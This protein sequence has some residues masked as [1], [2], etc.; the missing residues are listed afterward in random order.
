M[1]TAARLFLCITVK[2]FDNTHNGRVDAEDDGQEGWDFSMSVSPFLLYF[3]KIAVDI[4]NK[5]GL[6]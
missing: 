1:I 4:P 6:S 3:R 5:P 2:R